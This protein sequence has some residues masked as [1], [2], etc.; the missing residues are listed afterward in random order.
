MKLIYLLLLLIGVPLI[1]ITVGNLTID[2]WNKIVRNIKGLWTILTTV[3]IIIIIG[4]L[5]VFV[6]AMMGNLMFFITGWVSKHIITIIC[7]CI[8]I[9]IIAVIGKWTK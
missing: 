2:N 9:T 8:V 5:I 1:G 7:I 3:S 4:C 6:P